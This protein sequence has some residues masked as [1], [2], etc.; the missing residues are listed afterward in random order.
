V[1]ELKK[2]L[3]ADLKQISW[4]LFLVYLILAVM[5]YL[6]G[7]HA[8]Y[9]DVY[10]A[11]LGIAALVTVVFAC[12]NLLNLIWIAAERKQDKRHHGSS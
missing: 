1:R 4:T 8:G 12:L 2:S 7:R 9:R 5:G 10:M 3:S 6:F 11:C